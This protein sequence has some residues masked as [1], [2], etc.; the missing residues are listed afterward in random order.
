[1]ENLQGTPLRVVYIAGLPRSG[2]TFLQLL[3]DSRDDAVGLGEVG[4]TLQN[5]ESLINDTHGS[6][7]CSCGLGILD[8]PFW[9]P[10]AKRLQNIPIQ[11]AH[12]Q[13]LSRFST[14]FPGKLLI[15]SS[16]SRKYLEA[17]YIKNKHLHDVEMKILFLVRDSRGW[18]LS[19]TKHSGRGADN[20]FYYVKNSY[21]WL[22]ANLRLMHYL[23]KVGKDF[24]CVSY[25]GLV[26]D[27]IRQLKR[28]ADFLQI[29]YLPE[30]PD[31]AN[32][33][34]HDVYGS[35][36]KN[37]KGKRAGIV[38]DDSWIRDWRPSALAP[39]LLPVYWFNYVF[40]R[41]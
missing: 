41:L 18:A 20:S 39:L 10:L 6:R 22:N 9:G 27:T 36:M 25:E 19:Y 34:A 37:D 38:Y 17:L 33:T 30:I 23:S 14:E 2:S 24:K 5:L 8:C 28:V 11:Q 12:L 1:M 13:V 32:A 29:P 7:L 35:R 4:Q 3:L 26:F 21:R 31:M 16:K 40:H 15:D